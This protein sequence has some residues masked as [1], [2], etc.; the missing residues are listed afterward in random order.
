MSKALTVYKASAGSGKT[1]TLA[2]EYIKLL[3]KNPQS[4]RHI[5]A[6]TF[7]NKAT[8]EMKMRILSQLYGIS[9]QLPESNDYMER[10]LESTDL[11]AEQVSERAGMALHL[12]LHNYNYFRVETID[13]FFQSVLRNLARELDLTANL[14]VGL[15]D[16]QV[17][18]QAVDRLID[19]LTHS[20]VMLQWILKYIM[21]SISEDR[22]WNIIGQVKQF[23]RTIFRDY[24]KEHSLTLNQKLDEEG[25]LEGY[26]GQMRQIKKSAAEH[27]QQY[28]DSFFDTLQSEGLSDSDLPY[29]KSGVAGFFYKLR[30]G[31]LDEGIVGA[32]VADCQGD[33]S[34]WYKK[35]ADN[36]DHIHALADSTLI[37]LLRQAMEDRPRQYRLFKSA[38]L[39]LRHLNQLRLLGSI[40]R[41][42][43]LMNEE[44]NRFLLSDTQQLLHSL[45]KDSDSPFIFE[46]IGTQLEH[47][48]IDEFQDTSTVQWQNFKVLLE[49]CMSH[50]DTENLIVGD[51]KQ[52]IY[53]WRSGDW[54][55]LNAI[56][57]EF[58]HADQVMDILPLKTNY[59]SERNIIDF[60]NAFFTEAARQE[61]EQQQELYPSGAEQLRHA[62]ADVAQEIPQKRAQNGY[63]N[64]QL[65]PADDY[66]EQMLATLG[67]AIA[68]LLERGVAPR[69]MAILVRTNRYIPLIAD[70]LAEQM[71]QVPIVS[72]E[73]FRLDASTAVC[74]IVQTMQLLTH[75]D[76]ILSKATVAKIYQRSVLGNK[77]ADNELFIVGRPLDDLLP[78]AF[79]QHTD[80]LLQL[81][82]YELAERLYS[83]FQ[84]ERLNEQSAYI[85]AFYDQLNKFTQDESTD[86]TAFIREWEETICAKTIQSTETDGIRILSIH[87][88]K[89]LEFEHVIIPYCDWRL[90]HAD[91]L[92]C[93]PHEAPFDA[94]P[95]VPVDYSGKQ[96]M[97][98]IFEHDYLDERLQNTVDNLNLL[99]VAFTRAEKSLF[100]I[101][102]RD[103]KSSRSVL[104]QNVVTQLKLPNATLDG[105]EDAEAPLTFTYGNLVH[106]FP[107]ERS[108]AMQSPAERSVAMPS[109][110]SN[111]FLA[112]VTPKQL[113]LET[114]EPLTEFRQSNQSREF[115]EGDDQESSLSYIKMGSVLHEVFSTIRTTADIDRALQQL[116][117]DGVLY[118]DEVT[119]EKVSALLRK[120]LES[121]RVKDWFSD[122]WQLFNECKIIFFEDG[123]MKERRP[124]RVMTD[125]R[126]THVVDFKF[127]NPHEEYHEQVREYMS[128]LRSMQMPRVRG[129]L[130]YIYINK[131]EEVREDER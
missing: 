129:W 81:P 21:E 125:G 28:A 3:V 37:P 62:Y 101:G 24:Y 114:F 99:Y 111:V 96:M 105:E 115:I 55:L 110:T 102:R 84:L 15:N 119:R 87:K 128:L 51:V 61:Y 47:V 73:A 100:V 69:Q 67:D 26:M 127:G 80:D 14:R 11:S 25:F 31:Q 116:Q 44:A 19:R 113:T 121:P 39:I 48:M 5:L 86:I 2:V 70:Y 63:V 38:D 17:E 20:D 13:T 118:D 27:M 58:P 94:L 107:Q 18:E 74:L 32:R 22:S 9:K 29:G 41:Q 90:E 53:R 12:L 77:A 60:N 92:W 46:K 6:V 79:V 82:L 57:R 88:S 23:G 34:K 65:L 35:S 7:T 106:S 64:V 123:V 50:A 76:D 104:V 117:H 33:P 42:V 52:S 8:E 97:G 78:E 93:H 89:G 103:D 122:R 72:D 59:R 30:N 56:D 16:T 10:I 108:V 126:E 120:R 71:P 49:E 1:F 45:I 36:R 130:W 85:C 112:P 43:R 75:P 109:K 4:Y 98:T 66:H 83:I 124:D 91:I 95:I 40:E 68:G 131:V 54:R